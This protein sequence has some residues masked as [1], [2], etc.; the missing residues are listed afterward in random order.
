M[1]HWENLCSVLGTFLCLF[2]PAFAFINFYRYIYMYHIIWTQVKI[3]YLVALHSQGLTNIFQDHLCI[4]QTS[5]VTGPLELVILNDFSSRSFFSSMKVLKLL[6]HGVEH[7]NIPC[8]EHSSKVQW[9]E[10]LGKR[11]V[12]GII[13]PALVTQQNQPY[14]PVGGWVIFKIFLTLGTAKQMLSMPWFSCQTQS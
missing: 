10:E 4:L 12:R 5:C 13:P 2:T 9:A 14:G 8:L 3:K 11:R 6:S 7:R 1:A